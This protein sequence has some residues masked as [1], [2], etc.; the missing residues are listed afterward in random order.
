VVPVVLAAGYFALWACATPGPATLRSA[1]PPL[2]AEKREIGVGGF[3]AKKSNPDDPS[4]LTGGGELW[5]TR[6]VWRFDLGYTI[7]GGEQ[8]LGPT[9]TARLWALDASRFRLGVGGE[10]GISGAMAEIPVAVNAFGPLWLY[11]MPRLTGPKPGGIWAAGG[12]VLRLSRVGVIVEGGDVVYVFH[13]SG[14]VSYY[15]AGGLAIYY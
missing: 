12:M 5:W 15:G 4:Q 2:P 3:V 11:G 7:Q 13:N 1:A 14:P 9:L 10:V 6:H 8:G